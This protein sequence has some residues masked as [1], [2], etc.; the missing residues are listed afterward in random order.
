MTIRCQDHLRTAPPRTSFDDYVKVVEALKGKPADSSGLAPYRAMFVLTGKLDPRPQTGLP[1]VPAWYTTISKLPLRI[2]IAALPLILLCS[3][4]G[5]VRRNRPV[6]APLPKAAMT[7]KSVRP[8][9][10]TRT[11]IPS[12]PYPR[13]VAV[14]FSNVPAY[15]E[16]VRQLRKQL[17]PASYR[18]TLVDLGAENWRTRL[19]SLRGRQGLVVV[20][21]GLH[22]ARIARDRI[23]APVVFAQVFNYQELLVPGRAIRGVTAMPPLDLQIQDWKKFDPKLQRV[24]LIVSRSH[25]D[26]IL[27]AEH[28]A[29][30]AAV[31]LKHEIS[32]SDRETFYLFQRLAPE[33]DGL[34]L[35]PDDRILSPAVLRELLTYAASHGIRV[36]VFSDVLL[37]WGAFMSAT[38][39]PRDVARTLRH[40]LEGMKADGANTLPAVTPLSELVVRINGQAA[41]PLRRTFPRGARG[42]RVV[43]GHGKP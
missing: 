39:S 38:P 10:D 37:Q 36:C 34:W 1:G 15:T 35:V 43:R 12:K 31:T 8:A 9:A 2:V 16:V 5:C 14:L 17:A 30:T 26:L 27:Q 28:A 21:I 22:A 33:I 32:D 3:I 7:V 20:A 29:R 24:G 40:V 4:T 19:D 6:P 25:R 18:L 23:N 41:R 13:E 11:D 42:S